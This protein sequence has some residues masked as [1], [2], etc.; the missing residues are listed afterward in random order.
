MD[1]DENMQMEI[2]GSIDVHRWTQMEMDVNEWT[3]MKTDGNRCKS[4]G[5]DRNGWKYGN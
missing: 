2:E 1:I 4:M 5:A 3:Q